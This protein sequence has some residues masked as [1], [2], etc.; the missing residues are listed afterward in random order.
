MGAD[1]SLGSAD[2]QVLALP[3]LGLSPSVRSCSA[4][5]SLF[6][7]YLHPKLGEIPSL[8]PTRKFVCSNL[9]SLPQL[10]LFGKQTL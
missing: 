3:T 4:A 8:V 9:S 7:E 6:L 1:P 2:L 10:L 5:S